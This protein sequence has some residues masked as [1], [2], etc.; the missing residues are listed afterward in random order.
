MNKDEVDIRRLS[1]L[2][3]K[4]L[5]GP[6]LAW[7]SVVQGQART[8]ALSSKCTDKKPRVLARSPSTDRQEHMLDSDR[9]AAQSGGHLL[10]V[11]K[12]RLFIQGISPQTEYAHMA[13]TVSQVITLLA[14]QKQQLGQKDLMHTTLPPSGIIRRWIIGAILRL[15]TAP[16]SNIEG[17]VKCWWDI[18]LLGSVKRTL[19]VWP[20]QQTLLMQLLYYHYIMWCN[21]WVTSEWRDNSPVT[22]SSQHSFISTQ[23]LKKSCSL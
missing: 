23:R 2:Q 6:G 5:T 20:L 4:Q 7:K 14:S 8:I 9:G 13:S 22:Y 18:S 3:C 10:T 21:V 19:T 12:S 16:H 15:A 1:W 17:W 11:S